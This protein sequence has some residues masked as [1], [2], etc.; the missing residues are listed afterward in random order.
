MIGY[1]IYG[2]RVLEA[3]IIRLFGESAPLI[4]ILQ[5]C[6]SVLFASVSFFLFGLIKKQINVFIAFI[7]PLLIFLLPVPRVFLLGQY[8]VSFGET[9]SI[10]LFLLFILLSIKSLKDDSIKYGVLSALMLGLST[11]FRS[12]FE[13]IQVFLSITGVT[14]IMLIMVMVILNRLKYADFK[15]ILRNIF[16]IIFVSNLIMLPWRMYHLHYQNSLKWVDTANLMFQTQIRSSDSFVGDSGW[17]L[18]G[19]ANT[20]CRVEPSI[21]DSK[22]S[23]V[24]ELVIHTWFTHPIK[25]YAIK[26][27]II[28]EYWFSDITKWTKP[29]KN[30]EMF[31]FRILDYILFL[32]IVF[33]GIFLL[34][35][36]RCKH[37]SA[38]VVFSWIYS[39]LILSYSAILT[40]AHFEVRYFYFPKIVTIYIFMIL[41]F[42]CINQ[43]GEL[44][45]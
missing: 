24:K 14:I 23:E 40:F 42:E 37:P 6:A 5:M 22:T 27:E 4:F 8:G 18:K 12:Y 20:A 31:V 15:R 29:S 36:K 38:G 16:I 30:P 21:C 33:I 45:R 2:H 35:K 11:Y 25:W 3:V 10:G 28:N 39:S 17:L 9:F 19:G 7:L 44:K 34:S 26:F 1:S 41:F 13:T 43:K 32:F